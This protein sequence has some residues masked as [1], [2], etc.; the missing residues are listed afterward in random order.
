MWGR[1]CRMTGGQLQNTPGIG[2]RWWA[3]CRFIETVGLD[4]CRARH[5][6]LILPLVCS[7]KIYKF[8]LFISFFLFYRGF[9]QLFTSLSYFLLIVFINFLRYIT[10]KL[11]NQVHCR[12]YEFLFLHLS[13]FFP[14]WEEKKW[15][16]KRKYPLKKSKKEM[17]I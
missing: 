2:E 10:N 3:H 6:I 14:H 16:D 11:N 17:Y 15:N 5:H 8:Y 1:Y 7:E 9:L 13:Y 12:K 4:F